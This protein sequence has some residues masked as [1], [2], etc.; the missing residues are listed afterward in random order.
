RRGKEDSSRRPRARRAN[1]SQPTRRGPTTGAAPGRGSGSGY[2]QASTENFRSPLEG[3]YNFGSREFP[4]G[5]PAHRISIAEIGL[6][7]DRIA[8]FLRAALL[9]GDLL[10]SA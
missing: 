10:T 6:K 5:D 4:G 9:T 8:L 3:S 2:Q 7:P 1:E